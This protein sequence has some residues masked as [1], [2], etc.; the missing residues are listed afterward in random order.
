MLADDLTER[1]SVEYLEQGG[2]PSQH[3]DRRIEHSIDCPGDLAEPLVALAERS[4]LLGEAVGQV[5]R[6][7]ARKLRPLPDQQLEA[8]ARE[9]PDGQRG[10][11]NDVREARLTGQQLHVAEAGRR[12][13]DAHLLAARWRADGHLGRARAHDVEAIGLGALAVD[14][15]PGRQLVLLELGHEPRECDRSQLAADWRLGQCVGGTD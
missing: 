10:A 5:G 15:L 8:L 7:A 13:H 11:C 3:L 2:P 9:L 14:R 6:D 4:R 12:P 1:P